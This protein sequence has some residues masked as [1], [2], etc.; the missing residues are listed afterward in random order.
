[1]ALLKNGI[2]PYFLYWYIKNGKVK[3]KAIRGKKI[4]AV[5][6]GIL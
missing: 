5:V 1:M 6:M 4:N 2:E 3:I